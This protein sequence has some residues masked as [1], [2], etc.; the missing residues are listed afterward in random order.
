LYFIPG[1]EEARGT[2]W[3]VSALGGVPRRIASSMSGADVSHDGRRIAFFRF[4]GDRVELTVAAR[5]GSSAQAVARLDPVPNAGGGSSQFQYPRWSPDDTVI[6]YQTG[7][8][9][10]YNVF[11]VPAAGGQPRQVNEQGALLQGFTWRSDG[12]GIVYSSS[13]GST[14]LYLPTFHLW[15]T[16]LRG[17]SPRQLT[18]GE[19]S[20]VAPDVGHAG[21]LVASRVRAQY[22]IWKF[23]VKGTP[24]EAAARA[25]NLTRQTGQVQTPSVSPGDREVVYL[26]D[27]GGHGNLWVLNLEGGE[28]RQITFEADPT[29]VV[30]VPVWSP[31]GGKIAFV[32]TRDNPPGVVGIWLV[33]PDGTDLR[34]VAAARGWA[35]WSHD[36]RWL[37]YDTFPDLILKRMPGDGGP[38]ATVRSEPASRAAISPDGNTLY[39]VSE[40]PT[41]S[42]RP[43]FE[44]LMASPPDG[45]SR[46]LAKISAARVPSWQ[47]FHPVI[48]PDGLWLAL[49]LTDGTTTN[50]W[51]I[52]TKDGSFRPLTDFGQR[53]T[54]I[55]RRVSWSSDGGSIYAALGEGD[56][57]V[58]LLAGL[59]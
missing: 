44:L 30:G 21:L 57:D 35:S 3:E 2:V 15:E 16:S 36:G 14:I 11:T 9:F 38:A 6:A 52:S 10:N 59:R 26:A 17:G 47:L 46:V 12:A 28:R 7:L 31:D 33:R 49:P 40:P 34:K 8:N 53:P 54:F 19:A 5:D 25:V 1:G 4:K 58:V 13:A 51:A 50:I 56:A 45:P 29:V 20:Y 42:G 27:S 37:L 18:F 55:A 23:P 32:S 48:S 22:D 39:Y 43:E 24:A 41:T